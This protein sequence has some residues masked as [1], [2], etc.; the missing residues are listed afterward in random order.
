[1][2]LLV[3]VCV[4]ISSATIPKDDGGRSAPCRRRGK[5]EI[6]HEFKNSCVATAVREAA[7]SSS[8]TAS[9]A[10]EDRV[11]VVVVVSNCYMLALQLTSS[12]DNKNYNTWELPDG[13]LQK[14]L[15]LG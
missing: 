15:A 2:W 7:G 8:A 12:Q 1:M 10:A 14:R 4:C 11:A 9:S 3:C 5:G 13:W 6:K